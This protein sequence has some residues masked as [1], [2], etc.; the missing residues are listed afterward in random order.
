VNEIGWTW[1]RGAYSLFTGLA[2]IAF[3]L[4]RRWQPISSTSR[5]A[6]TTYQRFAISMAAFIGG[7]IS[8]KAPFWFFD[9]SEGT[10]NPNWLADGKTVTT[11]L[12]GAYA[13]VEGTKIWLG[14]RVK[15]GDSFALPLAVGLAFGR[16]GCF[17][18]GCCYGNLTSTAWGVDFLGD[19]LRHPTQLYE[20]AFHV[21]MAGLLWWIARRDYLPTHRLQL[22]LITYCAF[23]FLMEYIRPE[24]T[25]ALGLTFYQWFCF[26]F[27]T[28][29]AVQWGFSPKRSRPAAQLEMES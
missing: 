22:Y 23:R 19:G 4:V 1:G 21:A 7:M 15:T 5:P 10:W 13:A 18:N 3:F 27:A 24:P 16:L 12:A 6:I 9:L 17:F 8:A 25:L 28:A 26:C 20:V 2:I 11:G 14:V 29:L